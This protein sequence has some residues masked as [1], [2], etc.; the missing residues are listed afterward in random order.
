[1]P[2]HRL[3]ILPL[4]R[5]VRRLKRCRDHF[6]VRRMSEPTRLEAVGT[7]QAR[8]GASEKYWLDRGA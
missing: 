3:L 8:S 5:A 6:G 2:V 1:M 4:E 7:K